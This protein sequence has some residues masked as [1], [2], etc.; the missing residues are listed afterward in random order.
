MSYKLVSNDQIVPPKLSVSKYFLIWTFHEIF[1]IDTKNMGWFTS[2]VFTKLGKGYNIAKDF[3]HIRLE[4]I[5]TE[6]QAL[7]LSTI[8]TDNIKIIKFRG[9]FTWIFNSSDKSAQFF[10][11]KEIN[12]NHWSGPLSGKLITT[13][14][15]RGVKQEICRAQKIIHALSLEKFYSIINSLVKYLKGNRKLVASF[16]ESDS[17]IIANV[18]SVLKKF[19]RSKFNS[20]IGRFH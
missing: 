15:L 18:L 6:Y 3:G 11:A 7:E 20:Y 5:E 10:F 4:T 16:G 12:N 14:I 2:L 13:N 1:T 8:T 19:P 9:L 17:S